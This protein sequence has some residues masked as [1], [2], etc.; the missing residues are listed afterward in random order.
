[1]ATKPTIYI[2]SDSTGKTGETV[3]RASLMQFGSD[4]AQIERLPFVKD[5]D[6]LLNFFER[7]RNRSAIVA[8]TMVVPELR[9]QILELGR[10][11]NIPTIDILGPILS[12]FADLF[13][14]SPRGTP[15]LFGELDEEYFQRIEAIDFTVKHDDGQNQQDLERANLVLVGVSRTSKTPLCIYLANRGWRV[16]NVPI[17]LDQP[18]SAELQRLREVPVIGLTIKPERL[19]SIRQARMRKFA[20]LIPGHYDDLKV[21]RS[22]LD[23]S[24]LL[25]NRQH[26]PVIDVT[27]KAIE[28]TATE[29]ITRLGKV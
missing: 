15:G 10:E 19:L 27:Y 2:L 6:S 13:K 24:N 25:F 1:M 3:I 26:W 11:Y 21:I 7:I 23:Y 29:I 16:A 8:Y 14:I 17:V 4:Q 18:L 22:E 5:Q 9:R 28:E 12:R 20:R